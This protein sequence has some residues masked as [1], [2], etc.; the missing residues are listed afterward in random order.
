MFFLAGVPAGY[1][2]PKSSSK[3]GCYCGISIL[4]GNTNPN[5]WE[6]CMYFLGPGDD[7]DNDN[8]NSGSRFEDDVDRLFELDEPAE[9]ESDG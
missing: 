4:Q 7:D 5:N 3:H 1:R 6:L 8:G 2:T 9:H